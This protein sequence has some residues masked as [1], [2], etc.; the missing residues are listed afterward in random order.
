MHVITLTKTK[1]ALKIVFIALWITPCPLLFIQYWETTEVRNSLI[2]I[3]I[4]ANND[5]YSII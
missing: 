4:I 3:S 5:N 1:K 2:R